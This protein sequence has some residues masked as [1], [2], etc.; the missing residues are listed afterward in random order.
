MRDTCDILVSERMVLRRILPFLIASIFNNK[1]TSI[2]VN[3]VASRDATIRGISN[4]Q[5][6]PKDDKTLFFNNLP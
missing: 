2:L 4:G 1:K 6:S 3:L 5:N